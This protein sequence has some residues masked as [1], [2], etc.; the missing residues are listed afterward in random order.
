MKTRAKFQQDPTLAATVA[1]E[2]LAGGDYVALLNEVIDFPSFLWDSCGA[3][4]S[5][6]EMVRLRLFPEQAGKPLKVLVVCLPF[7][8]AKSPSG[9]TKTIDTRQ[10]QLVR[11]N[12][13]CAKIVWKELRS[14]KKRK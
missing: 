3:S 8:Y 10:L 6:H 7:V 4:L 2:D 11:L 1:G 13:K 5:P 14:K 9:D 12:R